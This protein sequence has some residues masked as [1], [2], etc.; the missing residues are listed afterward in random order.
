[1]VI[2]MSRIIMVLVLVI[3]ILPVFERK[4]NKALCIQL[5]VKINDMSL[6]C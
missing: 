2:M 3:A 1:M 5:Y 6:D 4:L